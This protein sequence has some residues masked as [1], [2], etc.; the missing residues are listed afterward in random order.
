MIYFLDNCPNDANPDQ[1]DEDGD[2]VGDVCGKYEDVYPC[3]NKTRL[4]L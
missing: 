2:R 3:I 4:D 1:L